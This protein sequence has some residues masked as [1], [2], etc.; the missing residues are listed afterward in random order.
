METMS[1]TEK[2]WAF[3]RSGNDGLATGTAVNL[4]RQDQTLKREMNPSSPKA[5]HCLT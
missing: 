2:G 4:V 5:I 3:E 1:Y